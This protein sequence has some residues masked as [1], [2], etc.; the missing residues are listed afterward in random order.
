[1]KDKPDHIG[2]SL[3]EFLDELGEKDA[4]YD[5]A[6][7]ALSSARPEDRKTPARPPKDQLPGAAD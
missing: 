2:D 6:I 5:A 7:R 3:E 1:M 4:I